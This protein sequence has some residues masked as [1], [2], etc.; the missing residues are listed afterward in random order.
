MKKIIFAI[1]PFMFLL[2]YLLEVA[3]YYST[4]L[5]SS[6]I[7]T[8]KGAHAAREDVLGFGFLLTWIFFLFFW[9]LFE[10]LACSTKINRIKHLLYS[11]AMFFLVSLA[12]FVLF[13][14]LEH[15]VPR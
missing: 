8:P 15:Q 7:Y 3:I 2:Y 14:V 4:Y 13:N 1:T 5:N 9:A 12:D 10:A 6:L 11:A